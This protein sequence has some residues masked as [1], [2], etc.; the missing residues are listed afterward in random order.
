MRRL[1]LAV[2]LLLLAGAAWIGVSLYPP[3]QGFPK[4]GV[5]V[6]IPHGASGRTITRLLAEKGVVRSSMAFEALCRWR[7]RRKLVAGEYFFDRPATA[8][9]V[10]RKIA[11]GR[12]YVK[13]LTVPEGY[14]MFDIAG[15]VAQEGFTT[16]AAF[17]KAARDT[18]LIQDLAPAAGSLEGFLFP[19]TYQFSRHTSAP[20]IAGAMVAR[21]RGA[22]SSLPEEARQRDER[23]VDAVVTLASLVEK[24]TAVAAERPVIAG[25][26]ANRLRRGLP[27]QCDPTVIYAL[28]LTDKYSGRLDSGDL[29]F[30]SPYNTYRHRGLPPGPIAN[31]GLASLRA[32]LEPQQVGYFYFVASG[33]G[34]HTFSRTL[35]EHY[36]NVAHYRGLLAQN[37]RAP[38]SENSATGTRKNAAV[39]KR[40]R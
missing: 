34:G 16:R 31:P 26:F 28:E 5:F 24:E 27:L 4:D 3:Y 12:V 36:Q 40:R 38:A 32:A 23:P 10:F 35:K 13:D 30:D 1:L 14:T 17:L 33:D 18:S 20:E 19:A 6:E 11:E 22:W 9:E 8:F 39:P 7:A 15:L 37:G 25:V 21:F 29:Q 2:F